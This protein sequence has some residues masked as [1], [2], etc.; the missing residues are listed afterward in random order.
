MRFPDD[1]LLINDKNL[2]W[3]ELNVRKNGVICQAQGAP[4][5]TDSNQAY[6]TKMTGCVFQGR[7]TRDGAESSYSPI[8]R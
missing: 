5:I 2:F 1:F 3:D 8:A 4:M 7:N 6:F